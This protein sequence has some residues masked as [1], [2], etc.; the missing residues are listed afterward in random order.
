MNHQVIKKV[1]IS[2]VD[3]NADNF[4]SILE[5]NNATIKSG[6]LLTF[7]TELQ[8]TL[9]QNKRYPITKDIN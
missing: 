6:I 7:K 9:N 1:K 8:Q 2:V 5:A 3:T 4:Q